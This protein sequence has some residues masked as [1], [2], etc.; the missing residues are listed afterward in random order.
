MLGGSHSPHDH[1][2]CGESQVS[3]RPR[4]HSQKGAKEIRTI[5][6]KGRVQKPWRK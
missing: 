5:S 1:R 3:G 2:P 6:I 4:K